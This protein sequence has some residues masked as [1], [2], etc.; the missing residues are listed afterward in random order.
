MLILFENIRRMFWFTL[1]KVSKS[2][3]WKHLVSEHRGL[4]I[5]GRVEVGVIQKWWLFG[6]RTKVIELRV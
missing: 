3:E 6:V 5:C 2:S 4:E 1:L